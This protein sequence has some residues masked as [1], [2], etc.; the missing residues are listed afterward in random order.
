MTKSDNPFNN[1][2]EIMQGEGEQSGGTPFFIGTVKATNPL[3]VE[4]GDITITR[5]NMKLNESLSNGLRSGDEVALFGSA[6]GQQYIMLCR[7]V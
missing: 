3:T 6:D 4:I 7:V 5:E 1:L 2:L